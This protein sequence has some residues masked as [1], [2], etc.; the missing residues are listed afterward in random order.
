MFM[1]LSFSISESLSTTR[2]LPSS[3]LG[4]LL[5][6]LSGSEERGITARG[7]WRVVVCVEGADGRKGR[8]WGERM[9]VRVEAGK[10]RASKLQAA[11]SCATHQRGLGSAGIGPGPAPARTD[12]TLEFEERDGRS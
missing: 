3:L 11:T 12:R 10:P 6:M 9:G 2:A 7:G 1:L 5:L 8:G 4:K